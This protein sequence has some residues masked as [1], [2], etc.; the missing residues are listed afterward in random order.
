VA[1]E[2]VHDDNVAG[3]EHWNEL[4]FDIGSEAF[5]VDRTAEN[6]RRRELV[7]T[8]GAEKG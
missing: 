7:A 5:A 1:A 8:Q 2:I 3:L 6:E 4:L